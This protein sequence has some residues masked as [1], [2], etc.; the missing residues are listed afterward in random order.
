MNTTLYTK[1]EIAKMIFLQHDM[2]ED[3]RNKAAESLCKLDEPTFKQQV[4]KAGFNYVNLGYNRYQI[5]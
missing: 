3:K 4:L 1:F 2:P 5:I